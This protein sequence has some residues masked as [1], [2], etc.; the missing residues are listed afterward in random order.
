MVFLL[1]LSLVAGGVAGMTSSNLHPISERILVGAAPEPLCRAAA[2]GA[3]PVPAAVFPEKVQFEA[4][5][6]PALMLSTP[7]PMPKTAVMPAARTEY[8]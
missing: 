1:S 7:P 6:M 2:R 4:L 5:R 8:A 3:V